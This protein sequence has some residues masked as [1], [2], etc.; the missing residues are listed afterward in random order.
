MEPSS[1][2]TLFSELPPSRRG[3]SAFLVSISFHGLAISLIYLGLSHTVK[4]ES[5]PTI[6]RYTVRLLKLRTTDAHLRWSPGGGPGAPASQTAQSAPSAGAPAAASVPKELAQLLPAPQT[7][8]QPDLPPNLLLPHETP[9]PLVLMWSANTT[10]RKIIPPPLQKT[11]TANVR[12]SLAAPNHELNL[13]D[14]KVSATAFA[15]D[16]PALPPATPRRSLCKGLSQSSR[17]HKPHRC[18]WCTRLRLR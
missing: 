12:P 15:T 13:A 18:R 2:T 5:G 14:L 4:V 8:V 6:D 11:S 17:F 16:L 9:I 1:T 3:P 10:V 7:L